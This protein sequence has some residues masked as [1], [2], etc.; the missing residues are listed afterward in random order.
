M[1]TRQYRRSLEHV[2]VDVVERGT[3]KSAVSRRSRRGFEEIGATG[4]RTGSRV[5]PPELESRLA[6]HY[7]HRV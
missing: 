3:S 2:P 4:S 7:Q 6:P 5:H 1:S